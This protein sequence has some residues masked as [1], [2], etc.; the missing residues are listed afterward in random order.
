MTIAEVLKS[1]HSTRSYS[2]REIS[3]DI[4]KKIKAEI[5]LINTVEA[6]MHFSLVEDSPDAFEG[7]GKSYGMFSGVRN[8]IAAVVELSY[9]DTYERAGF[10]GEQLVIKATELGLGTCFVGGTFDSAS[11][12]VQLR[13]GWKILFVIT[14]GYPAEKSQTLISGLAMKMIHRHNRKPADFFE[15]VD[16]GYE[17]AISLYPYLE[18]GLEALACAPSTL[19]HQPVRIYVEQVADETLLCA[20][21][22]KPDNTDNLID[23]GIGKYNFAL[24][25][26]GVWNWGNGGSFVK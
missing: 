23:L 22:D 12:P 25:T 1:R 9:P 19:N 2:T 11:V 15:K 20:K 7:F 10:F 5:T 4:I 16:M 3:D 6:G 24:A 14:I 17:K 18:D 21:V 26:G 8:Y 13:A